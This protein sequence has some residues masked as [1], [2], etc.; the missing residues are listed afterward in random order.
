MK[1]AQRTQITKFRIYYRRRKLFL[2]FSVFCLVLVGGFLQAAEQTHLSKL[3][4]ELWNSPAFKKAFTESYIA[5]TDIEPSVT[6]AEREKLLKVFDLIR[7]DKMDE[8]ARL[9]EKNLKE[10]SSAAVDFTLANIHFQTDKLELAVAGYERAVEKHKKFRRAK[11]NIGLIHLRNGEYKKAISALTKVLELGG[12]DVLT[13]AQLGFAYL[14]VDNNLCAESAYRMA[15]LL[16]PETLDWKMLLAMSI[17]KQQRYSE[18]IALFDLL[19]SDNPDRVDLW[20]YQANAYLGSNK[21]LKAAINYEI[22]D[23]MGASNIDSLNKL[24]DIYFNQKL[25][26]SAV[27][28]YIRALE[29]DPNSNPE[30]A[31]S[32]SKVL[33]F[34]GAFEETKKL[35]GHVESLHGDDLND[36]DRK[37][38]LKLRAQIAVAEGSGDEQAKV[39]EEIVALDPLDGQALILLGQ[40]CSRSGDT[41][42][43]VFYYERAENLEQ[44]EADAKIRH[45]EL[46]VG[47]GKYAEALPLLRRA[48]ELKPR[49]EV[50]KYIEQVERFAKSQ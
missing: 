44:F 45:A 29:Q 20:L 49:E 14:S 30:H 27:N 13:Y 6:Q 4:L 19:I 43:A 5:E 8:A 33:V 9:I 50:R 7:E 1:M 34:H 18:A 37:D 42:K 38:L 41:E 31:I 36:S 24:G 28:T 40:H 35:M 22:I 3:E 15:V 11:K 2:A 39:L 17:L 46:L 12:N 25:F 26:E 16:D 10:A 21:P 47:Q 23:R 48:Q 32:V